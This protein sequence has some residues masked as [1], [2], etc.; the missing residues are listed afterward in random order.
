LK[1]SQKQLWAALKSDAYGLQGSG[2]TRTLQGFTTCR[3]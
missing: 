2:F 1:D 3:A